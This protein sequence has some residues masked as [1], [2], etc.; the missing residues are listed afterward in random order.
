MSFEQIR[1]ACFAFGLQCDDESNI[2]RYKKQLIE[3]SEQYKKAKKELSEKS[4]YLKNLVDT[5]DA[6]MKKI[7]NVETGSLVYLKSV[8]TDL[9]GVPAMRSALLEL[10]AGVATRA[11][12][13]EIMRRARLAGKSGFPSPFYAR[14]NRDGTI[15]HA[16]PVPSLVNKKVPSV[17]CPTCYRRYTLRPDGSWYSDRVLT[18]LEWKDIKPGT[19]IVSSA[20]QEY[21]MYER[22]PKGYY[23]VVYD[24]AKYAHLSPGGYGFPQRFK[25]KKEADVFIQTYNIRR[26]YEIVDEDRA[27]A[28]VVPRVVNY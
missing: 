21:Y 11:I 27:P 5:I 19:P 25:T 14:C 15:F 7:K 4:E 9:T 13:V 17:E 6:T 3:K 26:K 28:Y 12:D 16:T 18:V 20:T 1:D 2:E 10:V 22:F 23:I 24:G 8:I